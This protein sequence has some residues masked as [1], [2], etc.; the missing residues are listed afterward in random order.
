[1]MLTCKNVCSSTVH[2]KGITSNELLVEDDKKV[3]NRP[4]KQACSLPAHG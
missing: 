1:M 3:I 2:I 4:F